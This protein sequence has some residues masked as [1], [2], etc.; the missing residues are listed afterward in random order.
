[1]A[2][3]DTPGLTQDGASQ[4][5]RSTPQDSA[6]RS[7]SRRSLRA[8]SETGTVARSTPG[9]PGSAAA[10]S[11]AAG[12]A[13]TKPAGKRKGGWV[14]NVA[15]IGVA[16]GIV[17]TMSIPAFA[18]N[19]DDAGSSAFGPTAADSMKRAQSQSVE[20]SDVVSSTAGR[21]AVS[22]TTEQQLAAQKAAA[23][24]EAARQRAAVT[25]TRYATSYSGPSV[26]QFLANPPYPDF[27]LDRVFSVAQQ[28][29]GTPY[30]YGGDS[31]SGFD[32]SGYIMYV[33]SQFG[34]SMQHSVSKQAASGKVI[35]IADARPGDLVIMP[36]HDGFYAGN[37]NILDAPTQGKSVSIRP[38]WTDNYYIVRLGI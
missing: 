15:A 20:V 1:M 14:L 36:G 2:H 4:D 33:Y 10:T 26:Q 25:L 22:A 7:V 12:L 37:G 6:P 30:V 9:P 34:I 38:I 8:E 23:A 28:Y 27:S 21:E 35:A 19:P 13:A 31:P 32:C 11:A 5:P 24:A 16:T 29:I 17:A 18:F 3:S